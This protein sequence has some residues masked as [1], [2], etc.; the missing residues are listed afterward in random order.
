[1]AWF[2]CRPAIQFCCGCSLEFGVYLWLLAHFMINCFFIVVAFGDLVLMSGI[3]Y[4]SNIYVEIGLCMWALAGQVFIFLGVWGV[5]QREEVKVR[6]Y[7]FYLAATILG[8]IGFYVKL[9]VIDGPCAHLPAATVHGNAWA[10]GVGRGGSIVSAVFF[11]VV[12]FYMFFIVWSLIEDMSEAGGYS[13]DHLTSKNDLYWRHIHSIDHSGYNWLWEMAG[14][15]NSASQ[16]GAVYDQQTATMLGGSHRIFGWDHEMRYPPNAKDQV[17]DYENGQGGF[18]GFGGMSGGSGMGITGAGLSGALRQQASTTLIA[19]AKVGDTMVQVADN[20][21]FAIGDN[22]TIGEM[23]IGG[24]V[25]RINGNEFSILLATPLKMTHS[26]GTPVTKLQ[27][28]SPAAAAE[29]SGYHGFKGSLGDGKDDHCCDG[30]AEGGDCTGCGGADEEDP[31]AKC[32][33]PCVQ[34][35]RARAKGWG[36]WDPEKAPQDVYINEVAG[37]SCPEEVNRRVP[38]IVEE[39]R[40]ILVPKPEIVERIEY[41]DRIEYR[42]VPVDKI[43]EVPEI[44]YVIKEV[45][46]MVPQTYVHEKIQ[47]DKYTEVPI[48]QIQEVERIEEVPIV[49]NRPKIVHKPVAEPIV[50]YVPEP[51]RVQVAVPAVQMVDV[52][53]YPDLKERQATDMAY[54]MSLSID[55]LPSMQAQGSISTVVN[56]PMQNFQGVQTIRPVPSAVA[57]MQVPR[58]GEQMQVPPQAMMQQQQILQR[59]QAQREQVQ[60]GVQPGLM[61]QIPEMPVPQV[62][63]GPPQETLP[64]QRDSSYTDP[65]TVFIQDISTP[66]APESLAASDDGEE[67][68]DVP[69]PSNDSM[70]WFNQP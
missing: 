25:S 30:C 12:S 56:P 53:L 34:E 19:E 65:Y 67:V 14:N 29:A 7:F 59:Q 36:P 57:E 13:M 64:L 49:L 22:I 6:A 45:E 48:M 31:C 24:E 52:E 70:S 38:K 26:V 4:T 41:D 33:D 40:L 11:V 32:N 5:L 51:A 44:E 46:V 27:A 47:S 3:G 2:E 61:P 23:T 16:Y 35:C 63:M 8:A 55:Q 60:Q 28:M 18:G 50:E 58:Q 42:E 10:C 17:E 15:N 1:M 39:E 69:R 62:Q 9:I 37:P 20:S 66:R 21:G 43:I 68:L 54:D